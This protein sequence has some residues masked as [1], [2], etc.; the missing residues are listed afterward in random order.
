MQIT[1]HLILT[2]KLDIFN[3]TFHQKLPFFIE[4]SIFEIFYQF[5]LSFI[6]SS[7]ERRLEKYLTL[8]TTVTEH[9]TT[10]IQLDTNPARAKHPPLH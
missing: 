3:E 9:S 7:R 5:F 2:E 8:L 10:A 1:K 6:S 4:N